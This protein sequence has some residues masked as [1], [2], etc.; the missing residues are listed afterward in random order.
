[1][2]VALIN[3]SDIKGGAAR[4]AYRLHKGLRAIDVASTYYVRDQM[5]A[6]PTIQRFV[7]D[8][9]PD[10]MRHRTLAKA[11]RDA[12]YA[13][14]AETRSPD[15]ELFSQA[16]I[17]GD[18]NFYVQMPRADVINLHWVA[19]F[20]DHTL[21]TPKYLRKP[22]VWTLH[23]M[24]PFTGGCHYDQACGKF[25]SICSA[26]PLLGSNN[27]HDLAYDGFQLKAAAFQA[28]PPHLLH[29]VTPSRW[30]AEEARASTLL[31]R[32]ETSV[33]PNGI[34]PDIFRPMDKSA[35]RAALNLPQDMDIVLFVSNHI[36]LARKGFLDLVQALSLL[37]DMHRV[38]LLGV[39]DSHLR[40]VQAPFKIVQAE[41][42]Y[43][44]TTMARLY[45]AADVMAIPSHQDNLPNTVLE[46]LSCGTPVVGFNTGG[47]P[48]LVREGETGFLAR[49]GNV[50]ELTLAF[51]SAF[52][53]RE[54]L[55]AC[56]CR[57]RELV[58]RQFTPKHQATAYRSLFADMIKAAA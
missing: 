54:R 44:D 48:D 22:V 23:D 32:F 5:C 56:G 28:W 33:I 29:V 45:A 2:R 20:L 49:T 43:N 46:S 6:D 26:C 52:S 15:I 31:S 35:A 25:R 38:L 40:A 47:I 18:E 12:A 42:V 34:E 19:G 37:P 7:P 17:D 11:A 4:A 9:A 27:A 58:V 8:P 53:D 50:S 13:T 21:F 24:N 16:T 41:H 51:M 36:R 30:L 1:M 14:Y 10:A 57:A 39:G 3:T 55:A